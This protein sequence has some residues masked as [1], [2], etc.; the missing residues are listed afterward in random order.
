MSPP[1]CRKIP[2]TSQ[3]IS[4]GINADLLDHTGW[5]KDGSSST[6]ALYVNSCIV[7]GFFL[8]WW[9]APPQFFARSIWDRVEFYTIHTFLDPLVE[10]QFRIIS[11]SSNSLFGTAT[12]PSFTFSNSHFF[13]GQSWHASSSSIV[14]HLWLGTR[15]PTSQ[16]YNSGMVS[17]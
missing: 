6:V 4:V 7:G 8:S 16:S 11:K 10:S 9:G 15:R 1:H 17:Q 13:S 2:W 3:D 5:I 12:T 14:L